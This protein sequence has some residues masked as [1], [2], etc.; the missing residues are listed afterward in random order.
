MPGKKV[1][2]RAEAILVD[3]DKVVA[4]KGKNRKVIFPGG[5]IDPG[6][7]PAQAAKRET[8]E[9]AGAV[10]ENLTP[11]GVV[12]GPDENE[13]THLFTGKL[14]KMKEPTG[15]ED[16]WDGKRKMKADKA[17]KKLSS[18]HNSYVNLQI[19]SGAESSPAIRTEVAETPMATSLGLGYRD[20]LADNQG[21]FFKQAG[22]FWM[23]GCNFD[24]D[25]MFLDKYGSVVDIQT[26]AKLE[27]GD[28]PT[29]YRP[30]VRGA[31]YALEVNAGWCDRHNVK[32]GSVVLPTKGGRNV[33]RQHQEPV[34]QSRNRQNRT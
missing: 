3:G 22:A 10:P 4:R 27:P 29:V 17:L 30:R 13:R 31:E 12:A 11:A 14:K 24:L 25:I 18:A 6:E 2:E 21:M 9:E 5:G 1:R 19:I 32:T 7:T 28:Y 34:L 20:S 15:G 26:M 23:K 33:R 8:L 16:A